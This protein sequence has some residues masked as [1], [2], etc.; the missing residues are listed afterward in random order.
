MGISNKA[1]DIAADESNDIPSD[2]STSE[3]PT[4]PPTSPPTIPPTTPPTS[5]PSP[6]FAADQSTDFAADQSTDQSPDFVTDQFSDIATDQS[7]NGKGKDEGFAV[8]RFTLFLD[9]A[10]RFPFLILCQIIMMLILV[11]FS[12]FDSGSPRVPY[13][14]VDSILYI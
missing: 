11:G 14:T 10:V 9:F 13:S 4:S 12:D 3:S 8:S 5:S 1:P 6:D 2:E 7:T